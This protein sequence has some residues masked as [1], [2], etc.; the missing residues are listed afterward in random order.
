MIRYYFNRFAILV[1]LAIIFTACLKDSNV[2]ETELS[3]DAQLYSMSAKAAYDSTKVLAKTTFSINQLQSKVFNKD[4]LTY[5]FVPHNA[6][7]S[8][9]TKNASGIKI[10]LSNPDSSYIWNSRDSVA[11]DRLNEIEVFA[12]NPVTSKKYAF[13]LNI[14]QID[15]DSMVW[16]KITGNYISHSVSAQKT[17]MFSDKFF[18]YFETEATLKVA[19]SSD[20]ENWSLQTLAGVPED[21]ELSSITPHENELYL[22]DKSGKIYTSNDGLSWSQR[23]VNYRIKS[24]YGKLPSNST[25]SLLAVVVDGNDVRFAKTKDFS[26]LRLMNKIPRDFPVAEFFVTNIHATDVYHKKYIVIS[27]GKNNEGDIINQIWLLNE[28]DNRI[29]FAAHS[30]NGNIQMHGMPVFMYDDKLYL[31]SSI[32]QKSQLFISQTYGISWDEAISK[33]QLPKTEFAPRANHSVIVDNK[34]NIWIFGGTSI[35][36]TSEQLIEVWRGCLNRLIVSE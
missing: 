21:Y 25:D 11:L 19:S 5:G 27:G 7:L 16:K 28:S 24:I 3:S 20:A 8:I 14:H 34:N 31:L 29:T 35:T 2:S 32:S 1:L 36:K 17:V 22:L 33:Q 30:N 12:Q 23:S 15:P 6:K 18:T 26:S 10:Y 4:S 9:R 13:R